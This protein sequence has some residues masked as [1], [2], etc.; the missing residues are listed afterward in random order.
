MTDIM[1]REVARAPALGE[2][3]IESRPAPVV[4]EPI[5]IHRG[6]GH[7]VAKGQ[8]FN[9]PRP[10]LADRYDDDEPPRAA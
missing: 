2:L 3:V 8:P 5:S 7:R 9:A 4:A 1:K 6:L 10:P